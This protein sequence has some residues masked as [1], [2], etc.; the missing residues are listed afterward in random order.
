MRKLPLL[1]LLLSLPAA[2]DETPPSPQRTT[3][4]GGA[5]TLS[6]VAGPAATHALGPILLNGT[7]GFSLAKPDGGQTTFGLRL[8]LGAQFVLIQEPRAELSIGGRAIVGLY[9][10]SGSGGVEGQ[11]GYTD[12]T[13]G[14]EVPLRAEWF[15]AEHA[16]LHGEVGAVLDIVRSDEDGAAFSLGS[17][18]LG[19]GAGAT[20]HF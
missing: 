5:I 9:H 19:A 3:G 10:G 15:F 4:I 11:P 12:G 7:L 16:S 18:H 14:I 2:A 13:F 17:T 6:G 1:C 8:A 20:F